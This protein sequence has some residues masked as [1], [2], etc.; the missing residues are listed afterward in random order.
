MNDSR[1][2]VNDIVQ[3]YPAELRLAKKALAVALDDAVKALQAVS[4]A[5]ERVRRAEERMEANVNG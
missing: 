5:R 4:V 2:N 1:I 3:L